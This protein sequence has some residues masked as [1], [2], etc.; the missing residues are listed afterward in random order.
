MAVP[1]RAFERERKLLQRVVAAV[2]V[3]PVVVGGAG[4]I[5]GLP[6][7]N[8]DLVD[9]SV[10]SHYRYLSGIL[11]A[12]GLLFW[13]T[14]PGIETKSLRFRILTLIVLIGG[15]SRLIGFALA[16]TLS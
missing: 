10:A 14:I 1:S 15:L 16:G 13:S 8:Q 11:F 6:F 7:A 3:I 4:V 5:M 12:I 2:G 9:V